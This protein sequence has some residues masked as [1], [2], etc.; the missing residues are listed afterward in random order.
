MLL[1]KILNK[2]IKYGG[3]IVEEANSK[4]HSVGV[5]NS[6]NNILTLKLL[7]KDLN[8]KLVLLP[9]LYLGEEYLKG[10]IEIENGTIYDFLNLVLHR[11]NF[12]KGNVNPLSATLN[13]L[14]YGFSFLTKHNLIGASK[15]NAMHHY[16]RGEDIYDWML[17]KEHRQY[18]CAYF[19]DLNETLEQAQ[20]NKLELILRKLNLKSS[21]KILEIGCGWGGLSRYIH[22]KIGCQVHG[23]SLAPNQ[24]EYCK[25]KARELR[26]DNA[27]S[28]SVADYR[29]VK[30]KFRRIVN[31]GFLE[32]TSPK[33]LG[34][35]FSKVNEL[36]TD[37]GLCLTHTIASTE[38]PAPSNPFIEKWI[39][40]GGK[41]PTPSQLTKN[42]E[43]SGLIISGFHSLIDH[44][45]YTLDAWRQRFLKNASKAKEKYGEDFVRMWDF[46]LS[47]CSAAFKSNL[48]VHQIET[49]KNFESVPSRT[50]D[51]IYIK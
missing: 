10:N 1:T 41:V 47:S 48:L 15:R 44:Y 7:K 43:K 12:G 19:K 40:P 35:F 51:Y 33:F 5:I 17:D 39:F 25:N 29:E 4:K 21:D 32:H 24:I 50:R 16:S 14:R 23:I 38:P 13:L 18:S 8:W 9:E 26:M 31:V 34:V 11:K 20:T 30:G 37:D 28:Y 49:V 36:L 3:F 45:N 46:Y 2:K 27:L 6:D 42:I 22:K